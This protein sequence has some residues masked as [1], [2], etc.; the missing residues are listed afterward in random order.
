M[1]TSVW[2]GPGGGP[3]RLVPLLAAAAAVT[4]RDRPQ[5]CPQESAHRAVLVI[6]GAHALA[7]RRA[8][9]PGRSWRRPGL[10]TPPQVASV[11]AGQMRWVMAVAG[12]AAYC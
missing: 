1:V 7:A 8:A 2:S 9:A 6:A 12:Q 3:P 4:T 10:V 5:D 11:P